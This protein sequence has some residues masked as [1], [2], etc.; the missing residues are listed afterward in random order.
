MVAGRQ[1]YKHNKEMRMS[2]PFNLQTVPFSLL[3]EHEQA[4]LLATVECMEFAPGEV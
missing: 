4:K 2:V 3:D 1:R